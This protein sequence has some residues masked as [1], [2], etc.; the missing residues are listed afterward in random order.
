LIQ[1]LIRSRGFY[2]RQVLGVV[3]AAILALL[4]GAIDV[5]RASPFQPFI[6]TAVGLA[7][8][9]ITVAYALIPLRRHDVLAVSRAAIINNIDE[10]IIV[11][12]EDGRIAYI[13]PIAEKLVGKPVSSVVGKPL[14]QFL[15]NLKPA[16]TFITDQKREVILPFENKSHTFNVHV[17]PI[18]DWSG[19]VLCHV[20]VLHDITEYKM[21]EERMLASESNLA[22]AQRISHL[23]SW[24]W[25]LTNNRISCSEEMFRIAGLLPQEIEITL[26]TF[27]IFLPPDEM[28]KVVQQNMGNP[29]TSIEHVITR[30]NGETRNVQSRIRAYRDE[31]GRPLRLLGSVQDITEYKQAEAQIHLQA[32]ALESAVNGITITDIDGKI[33]WA[34]HSFVQMTGYP[35]E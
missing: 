17:S 30:P 11:I 12:D 21:A 26:E 13:N 9:T 3:V 8:G 5:L 32:A 35:I 10:C 34:N 27:G 23:G 25:D 29:T 4:G 14:Q 28:K 24:E 31:L 7:I 16:S 33:L 1:W 18:T 20:I 19:K 2:S 6:A 15:P 22:E